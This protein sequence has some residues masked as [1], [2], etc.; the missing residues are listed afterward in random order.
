M[1]ILK[2]FSWLAVVFLVFTPLS[3]AAESDVDRLLNLLVEKK[4]VTAEDAATFRADLAIKKQEEKET[5]KEFS[6]LAGKAIKLSGYTQLRFQQSKMQRM[7]L[8]SVERGL[9]LKGI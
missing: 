1:K 3:F 4:V 7:A 8:I 6:V 9:T 2:L 5:Q